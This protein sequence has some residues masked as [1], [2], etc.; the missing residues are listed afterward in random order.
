M[1]SQV[2]IYHGNTLIAN[3]P[4]F[5]DK[6]IKVPYKIWNQIKS[7]IINEKITNGII[8]GWSYLVES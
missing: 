3:C 8:E 1:L 7:M 2:K 6:P 4:N 5:Y